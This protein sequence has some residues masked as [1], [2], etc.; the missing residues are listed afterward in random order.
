[1]LFRSEQSQKGIYW[2]EDD[3]RGRFRSEDTAGHEEVLLCRADEERLLCDRIEK[4]IFMEDWKI[5]LVWV[6]E[7]ILLTL[8][9]VGIWFR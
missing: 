8:I 3:F 6:L 5:Y 7:I 4:V 1:M 9:A 2:E